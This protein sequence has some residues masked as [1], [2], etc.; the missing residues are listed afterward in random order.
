MKRIVFLVGGAYHPT[1]EQASTVIDW[2]GD[3]HEYQM[4]DGVAAFEALDTAD[5]FVPMGMH[6]QGMT[7]PM[8]GGMSYRP[9]QASHQAAFE[10]YVASGRPLLV[11]HAA[12]FS[13]D[14]WPRFGELIGFQW[15]WDAT[16]YAPPTR[17]TVKVKPTGHP[18]VEGVD[19][20]ELV[21][22]LYVDVQI[23][24]GLNPV[25]HAETYIRDDRQ[26]RA[27]GRSTARA[28]PMVCTAE[29]GRVEGAGRLVYLVNGHDMRAFEP[30]SIRQLWINAVRWLLEGE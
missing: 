20:Y 17:Y 11:H 5:L 16:S 14:D 10:R 15:K 19:D 29:G 8:I 9:L 27:N 7:H 26:V 2:L 3:D 13:Y 24:P 23:T 6:W 18:V 25:S 1:E 30:P 21:D 12:I 4:Y 28:L 22:E